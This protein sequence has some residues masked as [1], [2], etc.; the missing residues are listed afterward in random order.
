[1]TSHSH[2]HGKGMLSGSNG[3]APWGINNNNTLV[4][5]SSNINIIYTYTGTANNL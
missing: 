5:G 4:G 1:M 2:H 3:I